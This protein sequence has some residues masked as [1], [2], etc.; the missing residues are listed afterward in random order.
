MATATQ[1]PDQSVEVG[2]DLEPDGI[3]SEASQQPETAPEDIDFI[4][5]VSEHIDEDRKSQIEKL[6]AVL[7]KF[8]LVKNDIL[9]Q[10]KEGQLTE[11]ESFVLGQVEEICEELDLLVSSEAIDGAE[12]I[13]KLDKLENVYDA[14]MEEMNESK[15]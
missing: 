6:N 10:A 1:Y 8:Q 13:D 9:I 11:M 7:E 3:R 4:K 12:L 2:R 15:G 14:L 5:K